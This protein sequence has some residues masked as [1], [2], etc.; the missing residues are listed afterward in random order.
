MDNKELYFDRVETKGRPK[1]VLNDAGKKQIEDLAT[2]LCTDTEIASIMGVSV[3]TLQSMDNL[4]SFAECK[5]KGREK[6][7][8]SLRR[9]QY[10]LAMKGSGH[11]GMLVWLGKQYLGQREK[12]EASVGTDDEKMKEMQEFLKAV[13]GDKDEK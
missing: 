5:E 9:K 4:N 7:K 11:Y 10:E 8:A 12:I 3:D 13:K 1:Y 6:G 2:I